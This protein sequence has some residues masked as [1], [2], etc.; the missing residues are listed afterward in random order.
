MKIFEIVRIA[1]SPLELFIEKYTN[2]MVNLFLKHL[3]NHINLALDPLKMDDRIDKMISISPNQV[4]IVYLE[5][6]LSVNSFSEL[7]QIVI[8]WMRNLERIYILYLQS[9]K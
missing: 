9:K 2:S 7:M 1:S 5:R 4:N 6:T 3:K 8:C